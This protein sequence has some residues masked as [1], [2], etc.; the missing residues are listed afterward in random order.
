ME[1]FDPFSFEDFEL[2]PLEVPLLSPKPLTGRHES[3]ND[4]SLDS[5]TRSYD[6]SEDETLCSALEQK[7]APYDSLSRLNESG[8]EDPAEQ[9]VHSG[10]QPDIQCASAQSLEP[11]ETSASVLSQDTA[12][13][14]PSRN[15]SVTLDGSTYFTVNVSRQQTAGEV[16]AAI[17]SCLGI[18]HGTQ[19][20]VYR[21]T[22]DGMPHGAAMTDLMLQENLLHCHDN[23]NSSPRLLVFQGTA[24]SADEHTLLHVNDQPGPRV[25]SGAHTYHSAIPQRAPSKYHDFAVFNSET[26]SWSNAQNTV[27]RPPSTS[28]LPIPDVKPN[29]VLSILQSQGRML[30][31]GSPPPMNST[32]TP[33]EESSSSASRQPRRGPSQREKVNI[34]DNSRA[35]SIVPDF[36]SGELCDCCQTC[37]HQ[38]FHCNVCGYVF[39]DPCWELQFPHK[40]SRA[41]SGVLPHEKTD[42]H[43]AKKISNV[44]NSQLKE[45]QREK[46]HRDDIDTTWFGVLREGNERP[47]FQDYGR[48]A[49]LVADVKNSRIGTISDLSS[50]LDFGETLYPSLVSFVGQTGAGKSS[51]IKLLIDLKSDEDE[52]FATPVVGAAGHDIA[53][54]E[55]VHLYLDPDS[56][57]SQAPLLFADC[58]GLEGGERDPVGARL[59]RKMDSSQTN[60][61]GGRRKP[62]SERELVWADTPRK[63]SR[64]FAVAHLYPRLLYTFSDVIVFVLKNPRVVESVLERLVDWAAAALEKSSNQPV[65][66]HAIIAFNASEY[67]I[68]ED[69]WD[70]DHATGALMESLSRTVYQNAIFKKYAQFWRER[71]RQIESVQELVLSYYSSLRVVRI[72]TTGRPML[73]REQVEKLSSMIRLASKE[74]RNL[75]LESRMLLDADELQP[76]LQNAFD[77]FAD[78]LDTPFDFVQA[79]FTNSP[80]PQN[81]GGNILKLALQVMERWED[82]AKANTIFEELSYLVASSILLDAT[83]QKILGRPEQTFPEYI[84]HLDNALENFCDRHWPCEYVDP[85]RQGGRCVNV[86]SGHGAK[87]HQSKTGK[88]LAAG[89]YISSFTFM[90]NKAKFQNDTYEKLV[91]LS[92]RVGLREALGMPKEQAAAEAHRELVL[93]PFFEHASRGDVRAFVSHTV[94]FS[95]LIQA[96]EHA[97]PCGHIICTSCLKT[98]GRTHLDHYVEISA[99]PLERSDKRFRSPWK[100][101][102]K[103]ASCGVRVLAL[104]GGGVRG[105]VELEILRQLEKELGDL[106][107][108]Q[109]FFD[110]VVGTSTGGVVALGLTANNWTVQECIGKFKTLCRKAFTL[111]RGMN[112]PGLAW[113]V[114]NYN[115]SR[116]ET[117][118]LEEALVEA[119][120]G[121][122]YLFGGQRAESCTI[123]AKVAV[124]A[125]SAAGTAMV[126]ANYNRLC[127]EKLSYHF[128]RPEQQSAELKTWEAA[129][130]TSAAPTYFR[131]LC[132]EQSK[133]VLWDGGVYNNNPINIAE[134]ERKLIWT[135]LAEQEPD[136]V[137]SIGTL[138]CSKIETRRTAR[139]TSSPNGIVAHFKFLAKMASDHLHTSL[140]SQRTWEDFIGSR[141]PAVHDKQRYV[142][143]NPELDSQPPKMDEVDQLGYLEEVTRYC[144]GGDEKLKRLA[145]QLVATCF[146]FE[147][148][149]DA[150]EDAIG[151]SF[152]VDG[153]FHCR[154]TERA[155]IEGLG[156]LIRRFASAGHM[157]YFHITGTTAETVTEQE[158]MLDDRTI[159]RMTTSRGMVPPFRMREVTI[160]ATNKAAKTNISLCFT[161]GILFPVS[162]FPR[163]L[164]RDQS[165]YPPMSGRLGLLKATSSIRWASRSGSQRQRRFDWKPPNL[166]TPIEKDDIIARYSD[167]THVLGSTTTLVPIADVPQAEQ[168]H[169]LPATEV[170]YELPANETIQE[171]PGNDV[172]VNPSIWMADEDWVDTAPRTAG[173]I[174]MSLTCGDVLEVLEMPTDNTNGGVWRVLRPSDGREGWVPSNCLRRIEDAPPRRQQFDASPIDG[175]FW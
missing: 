107:S 110:L 17:C 91:T 82:V 40:T 72:P 60:R 12:V 130:A 52:D 133:Q 166:S 69:L 139:W 86:R 135:D 116:Y 163:C 104:D 109:K 55:D 45:E 144:I 159:H 100:V 48:Y 169:E 117:Q 171:L 85:K 96:P 124:T 148:V 155:D 88:L 79:S 164:H 102:L 43:I 25:S 108:I 145:R 31:T 64:N 5:D 76:Y 13:E 112:V 120:G 93:P 29:R 27:F 53:T 14:E 94:C 140:D 11:Q 128:Q 41:A 50:P 28:T 58:E 111:R 125:T 67:D 115:H 143:L 61:P 46:L 119:F 126:L 49:S 78:K 121:E 66:P 172:Q 81:F 142:R 15:I 62:T 174:Y 16:R 152:E 70:V 30:Q 71:D 65:L 56:F 134:R 6:S 132:H 19:I 101:Y 98:H 138:F 131:A 137:V 122:E 175:V 8:C 160:R 153:F 106:I 147:V 37:G 39:C 136:V 162:G 157:P 75:K 149:G 161:K 83:K 165:E 23:F 24:N 51:L 47:L 33:L 57:E 22:A 26:P 97:L 34:R 92:A 118:P 1:S 141:R 74:A 151:T 167:P 146:Y 105:I 20:F 44:L 10:H 2:P 73:I 123:N 114:S 129:R 42:P 113:I 158:I 4:N 3:Q 68:P 89:D 168:R 127:D 170:R 99:C 38:R 63:Q 95:C 103:P 154:F 156:K 150:R 87:G 77:H 59:K 32:R 35:R 36:V 9:S 173:S 18:T 90:A 84:E 21:M 54:S 80:I 7:A